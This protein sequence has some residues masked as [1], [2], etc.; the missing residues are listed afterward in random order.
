[1][2]SW[3]SLQE[4]DFVF[5]RVTALTLLETNV[6]LL[7]GTLLSARITKSFLGDIPSFAIEVQVVD[8]MGKRE[9]C[10]SFPGMYVV[11]TLYALHMQH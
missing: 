10:L 6:N 2:L 1:M 9:M 3:P 4:E 5:Q 11:Y 7:F 8:E